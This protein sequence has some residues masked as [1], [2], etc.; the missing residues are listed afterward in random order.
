MGRGGGRRGGGARGPGRVRQ[1][2]LGGRLEEGVGKMVRAVTV[3]YKI[4]GLR[5]RLGSQNGRGLG[6]DRGWGKT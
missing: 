2:R 6:L 4:Q 3:G 1:E 5:R